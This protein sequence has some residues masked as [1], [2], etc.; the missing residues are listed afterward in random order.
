MATKNMR[1]NNRAIG[2]AGMALNNSTNYASRQKDGTTVPVNTPF[3]DLSAAFG[4]APTTV[5]VVASQ[6]GVSGGPGR[7]CQVIGSGVWADESPVAFTFSSAGTSSSTPGAN[8]GNC[9][10]IGIG[11]DWTAGEMD[12]TTTPTPGLLANTAGK[13]VACFDIGCKAG[14]L[15][16]A[17]KG[18]GN[19]ND[20]LRGAGA[21]NGETAGTIHSPG[22]CM[23]AYGLVLAWCSVSNYRAMFG[24]GNDWPQVASSLCQYDDATAKW[25]L[26]NQLADSAATDDG[27]PTTPAGRP[28]TRGGLWNNLFWTAEDKNVDQPLVL[29]AA[30]VDYVSGARAGKDEHVCML[31]RATRPNAFST[32]WTV[33]ASEVFRIADTAGNQ[34]FHSAI[35]TPLGVLISQGHTVNSAAILL[36]WS[37]PWNWN[38]GT[39]AGAASS[40]DGATQNGWT[41]DL[42]YSG[43]R[44]ANASLARGFNQYMS[45]CP[46]DRTHRN[47]LV[48]TDIGLV[49]VSTM[50]LPAAATSKPVYSPTRGGH[51]CS[52]GP[53]VQY[54]VYGVSTFNNHKPG[55]IISLKAGQAS[56][57]VLGAGAGVFAGSNWGNNVDI[58]K[59]IVS[60][61]GGLTWAQLYSRSFAGLLREPRLVGNQVFVSVLSDA[62]TYQVVAVTVPPISVG[63]PLVV[64]ASNTNYA[65]GAMQIVGQGNSGNIAVD[66][67]ATYQNPNAISNGFT[68]PPCP[69]GNKVYR[70][71]MVGVSNVGPTIGITTND[72]NAGNTC[73]V[74]EVRPILK[75]NVFVPPPASPFVDHSTS[76][77]DTQSGQISILGYKR[78]TSAAGDTSVGLSWKLETTQGGGWVTY[79]LPAYP[80]GGGPWTWAGLSR[81]MLI[82]QGNS[83]GTPMVSTMLF[84]IESMVG[85][86]VDA[87]TAANRRTEMALKPKPLAA[88]SGANPVFSDLIETAGFTCGASWSIAVALQVAED[89]PDQ[90]S[91][92]VRPTGRR[93]VHLVQSRG[94]NSQGVNQGRYI[95][96]EYDPTIKSIRF[97]D[98]VN[99]NTT[100]VAA[101]T[102]QNFEYGRDTQIG[103]AVS[104]T[105]ASS[106]TSTMNF[107]VFMGGTLVNTVSA[108]WTG[109][110][111]PTKV[112][113]ADESLSPI[114]PHLVHG[115]AVDDSTALSQTALGD[116]LRNGAALSVPLGS[117]GSGTNMI[118]F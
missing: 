27:V 93:L 24:G 102:G 40:T 5:A 72:N 92:A 78:G 54:E 3:W 32:D 101:P 64:D 12:A 113:H 88:T 75:V 41:T 36:K 18:G 103:I 83:S 23:A 118:A 97:N 109:A 86:T 55:I 53:G 56:S 44:N 100:V 60:A 65:S 99:N 46:R 61:D 43:L 80:D 10:R 67:T 8:T 26:V 87:A 116:W 90:Y 115:V 59:V 13:R 16:G 21:G 107:A 19:R 17:N 1:F 69:S 29:W 2:S 94:T 62:D 28:R 74:P 6:S 34:H 15:G 49:P 68:V 82:F 98:P 111:N 14:D 7:Q 30:F 105:P 35:V 11:S 91:Y 52:D 110:V 50:T 57:N 63:R 71:D 38:N 104:C 4:S 47:F 48:A 58:Q 114:E 73:T 66:V 25:K 85:G 79:H 70:L 84:S 89:G 81:Y 95:S 117:S 39:N 22:I 42:N 37:S 51:G 112:V 20:I 108:T 76:P 9:L 31:M 77:Y 33:T 106:T 45:V 96:V